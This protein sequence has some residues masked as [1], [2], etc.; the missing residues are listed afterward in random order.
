MTTHSFLP[1]MFFGLKYQGWRVYYTY[2]LCEAKTQ[3]KTFLWL[4]LPKII[5]SILSIAK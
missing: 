5:A 4:E 3:V 1:L 2:Q